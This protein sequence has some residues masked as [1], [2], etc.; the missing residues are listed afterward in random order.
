VLW[1]LNESEKNFAG[2]KIDYYNK[3]PTDARKA[4]FK[5]AFT[6]SLFFLSLEH[7]LLYAG[8]IDAFPPLSRLLL[9]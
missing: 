5:K 6:S 9:L 4:F 3:Q 7:R 1:S 8:D 2:G